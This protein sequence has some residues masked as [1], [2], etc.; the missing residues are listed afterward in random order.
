M[1]YVNIPYYVENDRVERG[2]AAKE[3][4]LLDIGE[5]DRY[6]AFAAIYQKRP[7]GVRFEDPKK[8]VLLEKAL[9]R[10]GIPYRTTPESEYKYEEMID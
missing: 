3:L 8:A 9:S 5:G 10:L 7:R 4:Q 2:M 6:E 1:V